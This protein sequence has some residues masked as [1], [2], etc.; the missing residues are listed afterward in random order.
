MNDD[1][2]LIA[3]VDLDCLA[4]GK[5]DGQQIARAKRK[6]GEGPRSGVDMVGKQ[7]RGR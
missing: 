6:G 4:I 2:M 1:G 5:S 3:G 7:G